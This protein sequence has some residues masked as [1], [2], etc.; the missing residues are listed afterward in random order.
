[1]DQQ[2]AAA[3]RAAIVCGFGAAVLYFAV[4]WLLGQCLPEQP[5][6]CNL[7]QPVPILLWAK[8]R[9]QALGLCLPK[10]GWAAPAVLFGALALAAAWLLPTA[11]SPVVSIAGVVRL[12]LAVPLAEELVFRGAV[13]GF[14]QPLGSRET[15]LTAAMLFAVQHG[16]A[17]GML[18]AFG[19][20]LVL[21][22]LRERTQSVLPCILLHSV[23]NLL[24]LLAG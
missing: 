13:Q 19:V 21:G 18:Y 17:A 9:G 12:C 2:K 14:L 5:L 8:R 16:G 20:G 24:V 10:G 11:G 4:G 23:N 3:R 1:M 6:L 15:I 22:W 7:L